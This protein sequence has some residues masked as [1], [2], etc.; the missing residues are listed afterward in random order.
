[1]KKQTKETGNYLNF[2]IGLLGDSLKSG[3]MWS[4]YIH[5]IANYTLTNQKS[6][7]TIAETLDFLYI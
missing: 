6:L 3:W 7:L 5:I 4:H 2:N 1:M